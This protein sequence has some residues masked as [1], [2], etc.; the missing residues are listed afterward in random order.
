MKTALAWFGG[1]IAVLWLLGSLDIGEFRLWY[2]LGKPPDY[3]CEGK[4]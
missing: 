2:G 3:W 4:Q 1:F